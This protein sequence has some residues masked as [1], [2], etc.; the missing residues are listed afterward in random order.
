MEVQEIRPTLLRS[1]FS[2]DTVDCAL[3]DASSCDSTSES[4]SP[5]MSLSHSHSFAADDG[6]I[7][8]DFDEEK[9]HEAH[10]PLMMDD[11]DSEAVPGFQYSLPL[12]EASELTLRKINSG[13]SR[14]ETF[15]HGGFTFELGLHDGAG[16]ESVLGDFLGEMG[17]LGD[18]ISN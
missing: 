12:A 4:D 10:S 13:E 9:A 6:Y 17:Y 14:R 11:E 18:A 15:G 8:S 2:V 1:H 7:S 3:D 5:G 16:D